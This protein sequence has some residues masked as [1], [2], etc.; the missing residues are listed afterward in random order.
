MRDFNDYLYLISMKSIEEVKQLTLLFVNAAQREYDDWT[1]EED[2]YDHE[3]GYGGICH[4]IADKIAG[5][6]QDNE[7]E[8]VSFSLDSEVHVLV[9]AQCKEGVFSIDVPHVIYESG[10]GYHWKKKPNVI[11]DK[12][13]IVYYQIYEDPDKF[14]EYLD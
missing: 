5:I 13:S 6:L 7:I 8:A 4:L 2:G 12:D 3:V 11:F 1:Q 14:K 10:G 9:V